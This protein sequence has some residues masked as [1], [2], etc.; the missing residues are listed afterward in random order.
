MP[1]GEHRGKPLATV[2]T[3]NLRE[4][5]AFIRANPARFPD[6]GPEVL[7]DMEAVIALRERVDES[8]GEVQD[9]E[10]DDYAAAE[11]AALQEEGA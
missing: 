3:E 8:I 1:A 10:G 6:V 9:D 7:A 4:A 11:R 2:P 5:H